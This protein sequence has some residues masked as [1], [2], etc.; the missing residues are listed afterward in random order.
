[1]A[2]VLAAGAGHF[3]CSTCGCAVGLLGWTVE[4]V[5]HLH[6]GSAPLLAALPPL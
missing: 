4:H 2:Q 3:S 1:M 5:P 6:A